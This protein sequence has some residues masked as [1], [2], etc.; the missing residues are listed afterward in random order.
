M[1][2]CPRASAFEVLV[3]KGSLVSEPKPNFAKVKMLVNLT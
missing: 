1:L 2:S 3:F